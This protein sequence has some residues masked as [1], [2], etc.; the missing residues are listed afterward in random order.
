[1]KGFIRLFPLNWVIFPGEVVNLH[2]FEPRYRQLIA[3]CAESDEPFGIPFFDSG[4]Q[5]FGTMLKIEKIIKKYSDGKSDIS[6][7]GLE[8]FELLKFNNIV[9]G[10]PYPGGTIKTIPI[11]YNFDEK[12]AVLLETLIEK[13]FDILGMRPNLARIEPDKLSYLF[14]HKL[15]L[16]QKKE[17]E[18]LLIEDESGRQQYLI[19]HL[20]RTIPTME[21]LEVA[22]NRI[23]LNGHFKKFDPLQF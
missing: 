16:D 11:T 5:R 21:Q 10:K 22:K 3:E 23:K 20:E 14:G 15:G 2:I 8:P 6:A 7:I 1:M 4:V 12:E 13:F 18:L 17:M 9:E 19:E